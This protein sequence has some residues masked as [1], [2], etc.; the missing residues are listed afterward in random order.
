M[1][2]VKQPGNVQSHGAI[3]PLSSKGAMA[4]GKTGQAHH[5]QPAHRHI[6][7]AFTLRRSAVAWDLLLLFSQ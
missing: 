6:T 7:C 1:T 4:S 5:C 3:A 2:D